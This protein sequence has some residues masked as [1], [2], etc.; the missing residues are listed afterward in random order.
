MALEVRTLRDQTEKENP[1]ALYPIDQRLFL[2]AAKDK[3]VPEES[4]EAA[5]LYGS[6]GDEVDLEEAQRFGLVGG[7]RRSTSTTSSSSTSTDT[8]KV[9]DRVA[10]LNAKDAIE[11]VA[12][13]DADKLEVFA[14]VEK[15]RGGKVD[16]RE[17]SPRTTVLDAIEARRAE[18]AKA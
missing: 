14:A 4:P 9:S 6:P 10:K 1:M 15:A 11:H 2:N 8:P 13:L 3:L 16:G 5:F 12:K 18:L 17:V 7:G